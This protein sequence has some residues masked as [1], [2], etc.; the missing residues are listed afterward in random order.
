MK[1][2]AQSVVVYAYISSHPVLGSI[3]ITCSYF[4]VDSANSSDIE[5]KA[6]ALAWRAKV[7]P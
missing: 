3:K 1:L 2:A 5:V 4:M 7:A 6:R